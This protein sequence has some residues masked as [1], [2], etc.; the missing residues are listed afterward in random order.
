MN[1]TLRKYGFLDWSGD[2]G[3]KFALGSSPY[4]S[5]CIVSSV[6]YGT[7]R[8]GLLDLRQHLG[9]PQSFVF[10]FARNSTTIRAAFFAAL[11]HLPWDGAVLLVDKRE[12]SAEFKK[13]RDPIFYGH[14]MGH[15]L[16]RGPTT[17]LEVRRLRWMRNTSKAS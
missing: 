7:L 1:R 4:L 9:L 6:G 10:H 2:S 15:L 8:Q 14:F 13:M 17:I 3:F 5:L 16:A 11:P 12:L